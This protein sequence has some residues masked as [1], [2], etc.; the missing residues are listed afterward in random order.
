MVYYGIE[1]K[2]ISLTAL[3]AA[4]IPIILNIII[5]VPEIIP[6]VTKVEVILFK[7]RIDLISLYFNGTLTIFPLDFIIP[8]YCPSICSIFLYLCFVLSVLVITILLLAAA[9]SE[10]VTE[11]F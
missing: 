9:T 4:L 1:G 7:G 6:T 3:F 11:V 10:M 8:K 2:E 5:T